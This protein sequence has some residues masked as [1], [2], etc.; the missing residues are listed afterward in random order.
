MKY[1]IPKGT[2][3]TLIEYVDAPNGRYISSSL[4]Y[5][6][7][8]TVVYTDRDISVCIDYS[9]PF[10]YS[11]FRFFIPKTDQPWN[12]LEV[13]SWNVEQIDESVE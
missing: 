12:A 10:P 5:V 6:T 13:E 1:R 8:R 7:A 4:S 9:E 3:V 2:T 11:K